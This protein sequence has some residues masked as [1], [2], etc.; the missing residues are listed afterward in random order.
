MGDAVR[1]ERILLNLVNNAIDA[2]DRP[3][4]ITI[5][6]ERL[7]SDLGPVASIIVQDEGCGIPPENLETIFKPFFTTKSAG[8]GLGLAIIQKIVEE[9]RGQITVKSEIDKGTTFSLVLP[10][11]AETEAQ[12]N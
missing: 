11:A 3:G 9:H 12:G 5:K 6:T 4:S 1:L 7:E 8:T 2:M 10:A